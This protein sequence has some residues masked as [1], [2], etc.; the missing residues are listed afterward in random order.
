MKLSRTRAAVVAHSPAAPGL[1]A[2]I[3]AGVVMAGAPAALRVPAGL[4]LAFALPGTALT[5][6]L[7]QRRTISAVER[8]VLSAALSLAVVVLGGLV[9]YVAGARL[10]TGS[11]SAL[12]AGATVAAV[13]AGYVRRRHQPQ[14]KLTGIETAEYGRA[15]VPQVENLSL[16]RAAWRLVPLIVAV[17]VLA[18]VG[19]LSLYSASHQPTQPYTALSVTP[20]DHL[21]PQAVDRT[22]VIRLDCAEKDVTNYRVKVVGPNGFLV[23]FPVTMRPGATFSQAVTVPATDKVTVDLFRDDD[24]APYRSV[25]LAGVR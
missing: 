4:L 2:V 13:I 21:D 17:A 25:Y 18:S 24:D 12:T 15:L 20:P 16:G 9:L 14:D 23:Q 1:L 3:C 6:A 7:F 22:V 11:W 5:A 10:A 8:C 19:W